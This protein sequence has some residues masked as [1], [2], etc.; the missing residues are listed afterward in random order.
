MPHVF[1]A[2]N[3]VILE[4]DRRMI[5]IRSIDDRRIQMIAVLTP[6]MMRE[7]AVSI[8]NQADDAPEKGH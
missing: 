5:T 6:D 7:I 2:E 1:R 3:H 8:E 4:T